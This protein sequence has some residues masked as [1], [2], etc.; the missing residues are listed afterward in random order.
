MVSVIN[1]YRFFY[2]TLF[3]KMFNEWNLIDSIDSSI[4]IVLPYRVLFLNFRTFKFYPSIQTLD[5]HLYT[6]TSLGIFAKFLKK[7]KSF[8]KNKIVYLLVAGFFRKL[9]LYSE[10]FYLMLITKRTPIYFRE[11]LSTINSPVI[12][13][14]EHPFSGHNVDEM[15]LKKSFFFSSF[16][17]INSRSFSYLKPR[18]KGRVK[19]KITKKIVKINNIID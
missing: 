17:F 1:Y 15:Q 3:G 16:I 6:T 14:Y 9:L 13:N 5:K 7:G 11:I 8:I 19:R 4:N 10:L 18:K 2:G 12:V